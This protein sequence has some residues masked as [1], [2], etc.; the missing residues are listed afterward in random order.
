MSFRSIAVALLL[1]ALLPTALPLTACAPSVADRIVDAQAALDAGDF[2]KAQSG[3]E[4]AL[5]D[6]TEARDTARLEQVRLRALAGAGKGAEVL[7]NL[8]RIAAANAASAPAALYRELGDK[9]RA[10]KDTVG[11][12]AVLDA[13]VNRFPTEQQPF[14][15]AIAAIQK[16][17]GG[18]A[19]V[20]AQLEALGYLGKD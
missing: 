9:L 11:A 14:L 8:E 17:A 7:T 19:A 10:A 18:D 1:T 20:N 3:A 6:A 2:A 13:G 15:D 4:A 16:S 5:K 12:I